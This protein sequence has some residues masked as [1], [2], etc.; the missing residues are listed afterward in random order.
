METI[1]T[2][3]ALFQTQ[4]GVQSVDSVREKPIDG[5]TQISKPVEVEFETFSPEEM[6]QSKLTSIRAQ[7]ESLMAAMYS[8]DCQEQ[9]LLALEHI[10]S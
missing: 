1:K 3:V 6:V 5:W 2:S 9:E 7:R 8:L 10:E 4:Y